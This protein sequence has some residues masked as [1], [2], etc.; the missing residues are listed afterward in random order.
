ML[1]THSLSPLYLAILNNNNEVA[2]YLLQHGARAFFQES[3]LEKDRSPIFLAIRNQNIEILRSIFTTCSAEEQIEMKTSQGLTPV[4]YAAKNRFHQALNSLI[5]LNSTSINEEDNSCKT[6][7]LYVL[8]AEPFDRKLANRLIHEYGADV[9]HIDQYGTPLLIKL[10]QQ[11]KGGLLDFLLSSKQLLIHLPDS[12]GRDACDY[13]KENG[14]ALHLRE[15][16]SCSKR[17]K[18]N[19]M[20]ELSLKQTNPDGAAAGTNA[21]KRRASILM[22]NRPAIMIQNGMSE[23]QAGVKPKEE[24]LGDNLQRQKSKDSVNFRGLKSPSSSVMRSPQKHK[25]Q[26]DQLSLAHQNSREVPTVIQETIEEPLDPKVQE[27]MKQQI[28]EMEERQ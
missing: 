10:V 18:M 22:Q 24:K 21:A 7:L 17:M 3:D 4:M 8:E 28:K 13:A 14:L 12:S 16:L 25:T 19:D 9:N 6:I 27:E 5:E 26:A 20:Q 15:F 11:K 23:S 2:K 1:N